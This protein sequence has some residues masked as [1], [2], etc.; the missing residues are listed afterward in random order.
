MAAALGAYEN[1][2]EDILIIEREKEYGGILQQ[3]I[4]PGFGLT[5]FN[6]ELTGPEYYSRFTEKAEALGVE[7]LLDSMVLDVDAD[8]GKVTCVNGKYG[9][10]NVEAGSVVL[11][12]GCRERTRENIVIPGTRPAGLYSLDCDDNQITRLTVGKKPDLHFL[13]CTGNQ[14]TKINLQGIP[15][16]FALAVPEG[17]C[18]SIGTD[19]SLVTDAGV[20][21]I[22]PEA[23]EEEPFVPIPQ[24]KEHFPDDAF[25]KY[26]F[27]HADKDQNQQLVTM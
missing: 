6:E 8:G 14:L 27:D 11:A 12:M 24:D 19:Y 15:D 21:V 22:L 17:N 13:S 3:C 26:V 20:E 5:R 4:H 25:R 23:G 1:G 9:V 18:W 7:Y 10:T 2:I 16:L